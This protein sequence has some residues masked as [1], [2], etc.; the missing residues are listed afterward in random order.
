M[1][2]HKKGNTPAPVEAVLFDIVQF[3]MVAVHKFCIKIP[4]RK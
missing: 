3:M 4:G 1:T 2:V